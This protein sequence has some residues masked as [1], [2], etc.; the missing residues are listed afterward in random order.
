M[1]TPDGWTEPEAKWVMSK[2]AEIRRAQILADEANNRWKRINAAINEKHSTESA[3][4][5]ARGDFAKSD[6]MKAQEKE[7][8]L[9]LKDALS[10][11]NWHSR[12]AERHIHDVN[13]F[14]K[15]KE[16]GIL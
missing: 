2:W 6:L 3:R 7:A 16:I 5:E 8:S 11:G 15:L 14:L 9:P 1:R 10:M 12:N 4:R 13:L